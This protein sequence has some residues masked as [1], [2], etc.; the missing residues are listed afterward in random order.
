MDYQFSIKA[1]D[2]HDEEIAV[3]KANS[4]KKA[5]EEFAKSFPA[6]INNIDCIT[7]DNGYEEI[8]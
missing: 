7:S 5:K 3:I 4:L 2:K 1:T 6:D 8:N